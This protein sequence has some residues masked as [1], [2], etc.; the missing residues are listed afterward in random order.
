M[1]RET[2]D[3]A[4]DTTDL[5]VGGYSRSAAR[6]SAKKIETMEKLQEIN[7]ARSTLVREHSQEIEDQVRDGI[8]NGSS[9]KHY[10]DE[11]NQGYAGALVY[12]SSNTMNLTATHETKELTQSYAGGSGQRRLDI[13]ENFNASDWRH[14]RIAPMKT[15]KTFK[16]E[17]EID[18]Y[19]DDEDVPMA[20]EAPT[21]PATKEPVNK[22]FPNYSPFVLDLMK[23]HPKMSE[24]VN[25]APKRKTA[26]D[27]WPDL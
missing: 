13:K 5:N 25:Q 14:R 9:K 24:K 22:E 19:S 23:K 8:I 27:M 1:S 18:T 11:P 12:R 20:D 7:N 4:D 16:N 15:S 10:P 6:G 2:S 17:A 26:L 21:V 3:L